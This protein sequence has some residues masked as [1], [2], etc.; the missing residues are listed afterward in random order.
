[1]EGARLADPIDPPSFLGDMI[2]ASILA[3]AVHRAAGRSARF[4]RSC[5][6][7]PRKRQCPR[8]RRPRPGMPSPAGEGGRAR[9]SSAPGLR[10]CRELPPARF[11]AVV[12]WAAASNVATLRPHNEHRRGGVSAARLGERRSKA[13]GNTRAA[14]QSRPVAIGRLDFRRRRTAR[15][16]PQRRKWRVAT[17]GATDDTS[18]WVTWRTSCVRRRHCAS[19]LQ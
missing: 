7:R 15:R 1:M 10:D 6:H 11:R 2:R 13:A 8:K 5:P 9:E 4:E 3:C 12:T 19:A 18:V 17:G 16:K 14:L